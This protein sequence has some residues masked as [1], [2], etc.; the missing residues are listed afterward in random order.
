MTVFTREELNDLTV[1]I[2]VLIGAY[3][4]DFEG[5]L[6]QQYRA[7]TEG[8]HRVRAILHKI[9]AVMS[10]APVDDEPA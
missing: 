3:T 5:A 7:G 8:G 2:D 6:K 10:A 4:E 1:A 9:Y